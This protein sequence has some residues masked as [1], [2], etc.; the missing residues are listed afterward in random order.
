MT[1]TV[2]QKNLLTKLMASENLTVEHQKI[3]TAK[4][5]PKN[6]V[7]YLPIWQDMTGFMYDH[8]G[9]HE[10]GH[11]LYTP[12]DGW[13]DVA[14]DDSKGKNFKSFLNV[15]EDARIEKKV[16]R[17]FPGLKTSF[18]KG[19]Q[20]LLDRDFFGIKFKNVNDLAFIERF[21]LYTK[22]QYT[23]D[24]IKF[25]TEE[26]VYVTKVQNLETWEDV[27]ALTGEIYDYSKDEQFDMQQELH[28]FEMFDMD[29]EGDYSDS[30]S[31]Y[32]EEES[33][34]GQPEK[35]KNNKSSDENS[36][37]EA[38]NTEGSSDTNETE[39]END[40]VE[41]EEEPGFD[42]YKKSV[43]SNRDQFSPECRTD[44]SYRQNENSLLDAKCKPYLYLDIPTVNAKNVFTPAKR[45][46]E[47]L[48]NYYFEAISEGRFDNA[49]VQKLVN[50]FKNKN[51]RYVGL[52]AKEFEMRKAAKAFSKSKLSDTGD[53][54]INK[55]CNYKFDDNIF[56][57]V[58]LVPK[59]K[60]HGLI[61]LL[62]CSG[63]MSDNMA[64]SIEQ[65]LVLSMFCRKVNI[66][67]SVYG[68]TDCSETYQIDRG[69]DKF[70]NRRNDDRSFSA[71][72][73]ELGFSNVQLREYLNS[74][75][76]NVEFTKSLRNLILL[77]ESYVYT[78]GQY[79]RIG[80]PESE[81][82]SN[83]PL[84]Q[85]VF[86]V[87]SILNNFRTT[88]NL[89]I[90]SLV[91]VHDGDADN[92]SQH[93][94][95]VE[96]RN[97]DGTIV[98]HVYG[99]GFDM[100]TYNVVVRDRKNKFEYVFKPDNTKSYSYYTN[101]ELLRSALE[102]I[103]VVGKTKVFG[104]FILASR[105]GQAKN[106]IRGR[107][108]FEDGGTIEEMRRNNSSLAFET[109]KA[110]IKKFRDEK[111]LISNTKGYNSF[112]LIAGGSDLQTEGEELEING[113]VTS[114]KLKTAFMKMAKKKQVNRVLVS[115]FIQGMAV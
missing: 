1:F 22:S 112:Y 52:L 51:D 76:S 85:A 23:A 12:A 30:D 41:P 89:D 111:F 40:D 86:A 25:T 63:S 66:P 55:L 44:D 3:H 13:H 62:D 47:L 105:H 43:E 59:G 67:F 8:L 34:D 69:L 28:D 75:M 73:G 18:R 114:H 29:D 68:F 90:T 109:E 27:L 36:E 31:D 26:M 5:D 60:S 54:D 17:K 91:I 96:R 92:A 78:R 71:K 102:W 74:K 79:N 83:T 24:Y 53:I 11:A 77:K 103:R 48:S 94:V 88:N 6:R 14:A 56:R 49:Y 61:L 80:R 98:K 65:I 84:V 87:G 115:K 10:V 42:R 32:D 15:V 58:M 46:Q 38:E 21:N 97:D 72:V 50:D 101:E 16:T 33:E 9:G 113:N 20:E 106:A 81:N 37:E 99:Y 4:F 110:L 64:G 107:Y 39:N 7:L 104:F 2:E 95:E 108:H 93:N 100:R 57:K 70:A 82:L 19:F 35:G 45:V